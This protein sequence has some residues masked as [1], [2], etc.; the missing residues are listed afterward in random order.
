MKIATLVILAALG[1][2]AVQLLSGAQPAY[3]ATVTVQI[4]LSMAAGSDTP[5]A[6]GT[7]FVV[8]CP[9]NTTPTNYNH[10][11]SPS[12]QSFTC[13]AS[14][15]VTFTVPTDNA[16]NRFRFNDGLSSESF[17]SCASGTCTAQGYVAY[18][19][20]RPTTTITGMSTYPILNFTKTELGSS[21]T[22]M[23]N[24]T[25]S[26][27][28]YLR[29]TTSPDSWIRLANVTSVQNFGSGDFSIFAYIDSQAGGR[30]TIM[31]N[32]NGGGELGYFFGQKE[33][34]GTLTLYFNNG[35]GDT[36][37]DGSTSYNTNTWHCAGV[38]R[39]GSTVTLYLDGKSDGTG[40]ASG[41]LARRTFTYFGAIRAGSNNWMGL[42]DRPTAWTRALSATE[43]HDWCLGKHIGTNLLVYYPLN[44][45]SGTTTSDSSGNSITG[46]IT[47]ATWQSHLW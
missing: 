40:T 24:T 13:D 37:I 22:E 17:T 45:G 2:I 10:N 47:G 39:S 38:T 32:K 41:S 7:N 15:T 14:S 34:T 12:V 42:M 16:N 9:V 1:F 18:R 8:N 46:T 23:M 21:F 5:L 36:F 11:G 25:Q 31:S 29:V 27:D 35:G 33:A 19:Q 3:A 6:A 44:E 26:T 28:Y 20:F 43:A 4:G 30:N